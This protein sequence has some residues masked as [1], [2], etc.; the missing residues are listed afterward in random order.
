MGCHA[1]AAFK[2]LSDLKWHTCRTGPVYT[3]SVSKVLQWRLYAGSVNEYYCVL[4]SMQLDRQRAATVLLD[5]NPVD[6]GLFTS[7]SMPRAGTVGFSLA[8]RL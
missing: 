7:D 5:F 8:T 3:E 1:A 2:H 6:M 4:E